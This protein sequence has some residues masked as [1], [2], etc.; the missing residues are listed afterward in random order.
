MLQWE[1]VPLFFVDL[2]SWLF[3]MAKTSNPD[4][5]HED[6]NTDDAKFPELPT[7]QQSQ[8]W[9]LGERQKTWNRSK[10]RKP[11]EH[12]VYRNHNQ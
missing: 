5:D 4:G 3:I 7:T 11:K 1:D 10:T 2:L 12:R 9:E 8:E 6:D